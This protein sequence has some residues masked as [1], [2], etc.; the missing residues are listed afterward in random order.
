MRLKNVPGSREAIEAS[1]YVVKEEA[2]PKG[3][4]SE[5]FGNV[6]PVRI[7]IGMGKGSFIIEQ[8]RQNPDVN[9]VGI[10]KFSS[11][12]IRAIEKQNAEVL[13]N[14]LF[15]RMDAE[16]IN[17]WFAQNEVDRIY[18]N[19]SDPW[20]KER[21][22]KRRLTSRQFLNRYDLILKQGGIIEFKTDNIDLFAFTLEEV[23]QAGWHIAAQTKD[24]H[25]SDMN[26]GNIMT[27]YETKFSALGQKI[28]KCIIVR[29]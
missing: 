16:Y 15:I 20:P 10:E 14:L 9:F 8:A 19:F 22:A 26:V 27:E 21:H 17:D 13:P 2:M 3:K 28:C 1:K 29:K 7:E 24:L 5:I 18:L 23:P 4:W 6:N 11:V 12:L 25:A